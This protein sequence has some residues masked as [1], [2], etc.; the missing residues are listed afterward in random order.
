MSTTEYRMGAPDLVT[1][2]CIDDAANYVEVACGY[3]PDF[4]YRAIAREV[5]DWVGGR[6]TLVVDGCDFWAVVRRHCLVEG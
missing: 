5:T 3:S 6:L 1:F 4:D 2:S